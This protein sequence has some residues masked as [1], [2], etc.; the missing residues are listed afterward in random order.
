M[1]IGEG[2]SDQITDF[3][4]E[5]TASSSVGRWEVILYLDGILQRSHVFDVV[6]TP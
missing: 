3:L 1:S 2:P 5:L 4:L 6:D